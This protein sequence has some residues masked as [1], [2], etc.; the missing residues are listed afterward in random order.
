MMC[1]CIVY[2]EMK[3]FQANTFKSKSFLRQ[4]TRVGVFLMLFH[5]YVTSSL[6][7]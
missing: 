3:G 7:I 6:R 4:N 1:Y 2:G 5:E